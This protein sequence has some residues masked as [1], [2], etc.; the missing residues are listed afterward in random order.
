MVKH[1]AYF[2]D[3]KGNSYRF[4]CK[5]V[6]LLSYV[7]FEVFTVVTMK[8]VA[9]RLLVRANVVPS[10]PILVILRN[11]SSYKSHMA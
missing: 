6:I 3:C 10:S 11:V 1:F 7:R 9:C 8:N 4:R 2:Q 5:A